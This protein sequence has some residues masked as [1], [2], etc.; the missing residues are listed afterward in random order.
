[1]KSE[2]IYLLKI[3]NAQARIRYNISQ[4]NINILYEE[5]QYILIS[6]VV[7]INFCYGY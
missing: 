2:F 4:S 1:M 7:E 3:I 6:K 5:L